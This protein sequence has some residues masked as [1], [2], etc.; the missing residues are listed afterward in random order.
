MSSSAAEPGAGAGPALAL[1]PQVCPHCRKEF[2]RLCDLNKHAKSHSRPFKCEVVGCKY[3][4]HGWPTA[5]ELERHVNDKHS[6]APRTFACAF[7]P[8]TYESKRESNCKQHM[9]KKHGWDYQRSKSNGKRVI[10]QQPTTQPRLGPIALQTNIPVNKATG[11]SPQTAST[12]YKPSSAPPFGSD[13]VLFPD[14]ADQPI[15]LGQP[16]ENLGR[17]YEAAEDDESRVFIP[18]T[19]PTTRMLKNQSMLDMFTETYNRAPGKGLG[20]PDSMIDPSLPQYGQLPCP[21]YQRLDGHQLSAM[22][23]PVK[24]EPPG[25]I[26]DRYSWNGGSDAGSAPADS[27]SDS[28]R[29]PS[30]GYSSQFPTPHS[31][32]LD[33]TGPPAPPG[34]MGWNQPNLRRRGDDDD[35]DGHRPE[36]KLKSGTVEEFTDSTMPDIF[37]FAHPHIYDRDQKEKYSPCHSSHRDIST[38]VRHLGRPAHRLIV[39]KEAI[40]SFDIDEEDYP[41]PRVGVCRRCWRQFFE[42]DSFEEHTSNA[43]EKVS[44]GKREKWQVLYESFT[45]LVDPST[46]PD[47]LDQD[48]QLRGVERAEAQEELTLVRS[49]SRQSVGGFF[50]ASVEGTTAWNEPMSP[51]TAQSATPFFAPPIAPTTATHESA[52]IPMEE[53]ERL[54][55]ERDDLRQKN[56]QLERINNALLVSRT[57]QNASAFA[58]GPRPDPLAAMA[59]SSNLSM[60]GPSRPRT[61]ARPPAPSDRD[62]LVQHMGSQPPEVDIDGLMNEPHENL[63][64]QNSDL[65]SRSTIHHVTNS[66]PLP[67]DEYE[68]ADGKGENTQPRVVKPPT[69]DSGYVSLGHHNRHGSFG[70]ISSMPGVS[71]FQARGHHRNSSSMST[72][73]YH[74]HG[75]DATQPEPSGLSWKP[76]TMLGTGQHRQ[77]HPNTFMAEPQQQHQAQQQASEPPLD[78][79]DAAFQQFLNMDGMNMESIDHFFAGGV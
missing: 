45:P 17:G 67:T 33:Y 57:Y 74:H 56:L 11:S 75:S 51:T 28:R 50:A 38:L 55:R 34:Q 6:A 71:D 62:S 2:P 21:G 77:Q 79:N 18:W 30:T 36:K 4:E 20:H 49:P 15:I 39:T 31:A 14:D 32:G 13:F 35:D 59:S 61:L 44:K 3:Y 19:S 66:P 23:S 7:P 65:S 12:S 58:H 27:P 43:C 54:Q 68:T 72:L 46:N 48:P 16:G 5:K 47:N 76:T 22:S 52:T 73:T 29:G 26:M 60:A 37:R 78:D 63:S 70:H 53:Y 41:H 24:A 9:E 1:V 40:S 8:C 10:T 64:R 69:S 42:R 25:L